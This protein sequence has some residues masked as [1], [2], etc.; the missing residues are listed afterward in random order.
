MDSATRTCDPR[1]GPMPRGTTRRL[2]PRLSRGTPARC[3]RPNRPRLY[4]PTPASRRRRGS[5]DSVK[6]VRGALSAKVGAATL[7]HA[8]VKSLVAALAVLAA[9][10]PAGASSGGAWPALTV[11]DVPLHG[12]RSLAASQE[13][14]FDLVGLHWRGTG[15]VGFRVRTVAGRWSR[16]YGAAAE[17]GDGPDAGSAEA[18]HAGGWHLGSPWWSARRTHRVPSRRR[19]TTATRLPD[20]EP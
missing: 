18:R 15:S 12:G 3:A 5:K 6:Q 19:R 9:V 1:R 20:Q 7:V 8:A 13:L 11:V 2:K 14:R 16:W 10:L 4:L 17:A